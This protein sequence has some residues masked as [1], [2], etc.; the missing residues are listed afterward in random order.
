MWTCLSAELAANKRKLI[1][2]SKK[3]EEE[4]ETE[5]ERRK[6]VEQKK[7][8]RKRKGRKEE[9]KIEKVSIGSFN[10]KS[11]DA[12]ENGTATMGQ[13]RAKNFDDIKSL[14]NETQSAHKRPTWRQRN[15]EGEGLK[16]VKESF[17]EENKK[18]NKKDKSFCPRISAENLRWAERFMT[19]KRRR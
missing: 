11:K 8:K 19:V 3:R 15:T 2:L 13:N 9:R 1:Q 16:E 12:P 10:I 14:E 5:R 4:R 17:A 7:R 6:M 18:K